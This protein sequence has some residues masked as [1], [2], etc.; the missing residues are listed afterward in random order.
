MAAPL[1][2]HQP[3]LQNYLC[4]HFSSPARA[5]RAPVPPT[6]AS[7]PLF[8]ALLFS[9]SRRLASTHLFWRIPVS[10]QQTFIPDSPPAILKQFSAIYLAM[11]ITRV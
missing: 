7:S 6:D 2:S 9:T 5:S 1:T 8:S 10:C 4:N 3:T 11:C